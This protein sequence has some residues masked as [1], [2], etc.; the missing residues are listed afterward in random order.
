LGE[1]GRNRTKG[2][3]YP[4]AIG[5]RASD[6][7]NLLAIHPTV[8]SVKLIADAIMDASGARHRLG[9]FS[10]QWN[11]CDCGGAVGSSVLRIGNRSP[12]RRHHCRRWQTYTGESARHLATNRTFRQIESERERSPMSLD[13]KNN[14]QVGYAKPPRKTRFEKGKSGNSAG[15]VKGSKNVSKL[16][17][18]ALGEPV[19]VNENAERKRIT[20]GEAMIKPLRR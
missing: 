3:H 4:G 11:N 18:Q 7:G 14:Y 8:K 6:E 2:W 16:L 9:Q 20:K 15:R 12:L 19:V 17:L 1:F 10:W 5:L 13:K